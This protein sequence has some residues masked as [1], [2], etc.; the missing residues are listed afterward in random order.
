MYPINE[1]IRKILSDR[2]ISPAE[3]TPLLGYRTEEEA[4][5]KLT[6]VTE[7]GEY[8]RPASLRIL[9]ALNCYTYSAGVLLRASERIVKEERLRK[10]AIEMLLKEEKNLTNFRPLLIAK[11]DNF[12]GGL[13][14]PDFYRYRKQRRFP[15]VFSRV[16]Y[17]TR[18]AVIRRLIQEELQNTHGGQ[19]GAFGKITSF[20]Y[21]DSRS[22]VIVFNPEGKIVERLNPLR[23]NL[24]VIISSLSDAE[25]ENRLL[26]S[27]NPV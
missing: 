7:K 11:T 13:I 9:R 8:N 26:N 3:L 16:S 12:P 1:F 4:E 6:S 15:E 24:R 5:K 10:T 27:Q 21:Y 25:T 14:H 23:E 19:M 22:C 17:K 20:R 2:N 18:I